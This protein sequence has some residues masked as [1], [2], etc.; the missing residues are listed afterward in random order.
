[1]DFVGDDGAEQGSSESL[2]T[3]RGLGI[4]KYGTGALAPVLLNDFFSLMG[5]AEIFGGAS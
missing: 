5:V 3:S 4:S 2:S 1:M